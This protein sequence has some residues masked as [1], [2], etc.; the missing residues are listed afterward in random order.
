MKVYIG[1]SDIGSMISDFKIHF[2]SMG[3]DTLTAVDGEQPKIVRAEVDYYFS[4]H[5]KK[6]F[7][8][9]RPRKFQKLLQEHYDIKNKVWRKAV[10]E[11]DIFLFIW[12]S[13]KN[14]FSDYKKLKELGKKIIVCMVGDDVRW[15]HS[16]KQ[17][18][19]KYGMLPPNYESDYDFGNS[20]LN[21]RL[22]RIRMA[23]KYAD[24]IFS[25]FDQAQ[26]QL[27]PYYRWNMMVMPDS[28]I[29]NPHQ[30]KN[31]PKII[32]APSNRTAKGTG[33]IL[34]AFETLRKEN[35]EF[36]TTL[37]EN[38]PNEEAVKM[39]ADAD[40]VIDQLI[41][42][43][44]GKFS[45]EALAAGKVV[46]SHMAYDCYPQKN[47]SDCPIIDVNPKTIYRELKNI[48]LDYPRRVKLAGEA[49]SYVTKHLDLSIF[50][51]KVMNLCRGKEYEY[52][53]TPSF[54]RNE[55]IP[56]SEISVPLYNQWTNSVKDCSWYK[57]NIKPG[58]RGKLI[59]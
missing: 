53:Y 37:L 7:G 16:A 6:Y 1:N 51:E 18:Y 50:C 45:T 38:I 22:T 42:P 55:F 3:A 4:L 21:E 13:F 39:Y 26:L 54:F 49:K 10:R 59:F 15:Y 33:Y 34:D 46:M 12:N 30:R 52:D 43:G 32:H 9:V 47:P 48:I 28:I 57:Q 29:H 44:T 41:F 56:E 11:C 2:K 36:E 25:R 8:G 5:K 58:E 14:D 31:K 35:I 17:E 24:F 40:I 23:E 27:R 19:L 20:G